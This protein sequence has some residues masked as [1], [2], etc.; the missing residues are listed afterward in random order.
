MMFGENVSQ[1]ARMGDMQLHVGAAHAFPF[2]T[3]HQH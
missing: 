2:G 3:P 1:F